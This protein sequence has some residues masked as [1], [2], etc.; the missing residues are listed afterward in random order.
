MNRNPDRNP[1][2]PGSPAPPDLF[3]GRTQQLQEVTRYIDQAAA[4]RLQNVFLSGDRGMGKS[5]FAA[6]LRQIAIKRNNMAGV[7]TYLGGVT[8]LEDLV[9]HVLDEV[10]RES[11]EQDWFERIS[12]LFGDQIREVGM[13]GI[14][15]KFDPPREDLT[16]LVRNFPDVLGNLVA[17]ISEKKSGLFLVL[18]DIDGLA[19]T[20][21]F[22][23]WYKSFADSV[24]T[25]F[26]SFPVLVLVVGTTD[27][28]DDLAEQQ[29]SLMRVF[30][31]VDIPRLGDGEVGDF[32][33]KAFGEAGM[34]IE[35][36]A[37]SGLVLFAGG[38]PILMQ[39]IGDA[40]FWS[41]S[42]TVIREEDAR[43]GLF[44][45]ARSVGTK[46]LDPVFYRTIRS[47]RYRS[48]VRKIAGDSIDPRFTRKEIV[49]R[50]DKDELKVFDNLLRRLRELGIVEQD[51]D[52]E[53]GAYRF[54]NDLHPLYL[55]M[56]SRLLHD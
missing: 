8:S 43:D 12:E 40:V 32:F 48:I 21:D 24:A 22:A 46:Y 23:N 47:A 11:Q 9:R 20:P 42:G 38:L 2:T 56:E 28:R 27:K 6:Y 52:E 50:L 34:E 1:F 41:A 53:P 39:E 17:S 7:H 51:V 14:S 19:D 18:D 37:L 5:S 16:V 4:G 35:E 13:F 30:Q 44:M 45:A 54:V 36:E 49:G 15:V 25:H 26:P 29:P 31:P 3:V 33:V 55:Y 10:L